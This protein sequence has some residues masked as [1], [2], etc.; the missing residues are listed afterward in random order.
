MGIN[1]P[2]VAGCQCERCRPKTPLEDF[3]GGLGYLLLLAILL[4]VWFH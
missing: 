2:H 4:I 1:N 3:F